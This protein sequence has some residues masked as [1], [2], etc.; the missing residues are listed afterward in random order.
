MLSFTIC[1][2][3][4]TNRVLL[5]I[6]FIYNTISAQLYCALQVCKCRSD[7]NFGLRIFNF[8]TD[9]F[10]S[11]FAASAKSWTELL[12]LFT[13]FQQQAKIHAKFASQMD[14]CFSSCTFSHGMRSLAHSWPVNSNELLLFT[15]FFC[16]R[17]L[18]NEYFSYIIFLCAHKLP[19]TFVVVS[20]ESC[21][22]GKQE[23][24]LLPFYLYFLA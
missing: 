16:F 11:Y 23:I 20:V 22:V 7:T 13:P 21:V 9:F 12:L 18:K 1:V 3:N 8:I 2:S 5:L 14:F 6:F 19:H 24:L 4:F 17:V 15:P 10:K